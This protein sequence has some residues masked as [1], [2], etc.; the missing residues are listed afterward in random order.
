[1]RSSVSDE[2]AS[3]AFVAEEKPPWDA[4]TIVITIG[5][6]TITTTPTHSARRLLGMP[7]TGLEKD[8]FTSPIPGAD[9]DEAARG[10]DTER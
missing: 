5:M 2:E 4:W 8:R 7:A 1:M 6:Q 10:T 3:I 9:A